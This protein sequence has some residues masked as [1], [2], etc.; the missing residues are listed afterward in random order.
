MPTFI[1]LAN[2]AALTTGMERAVAISGFF[3]HAVSFCSNSLQLQM[4]YAS[5]KN[6]RLEVGRN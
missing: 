1:M 6:R 4:V 3:S 5:V 2:L